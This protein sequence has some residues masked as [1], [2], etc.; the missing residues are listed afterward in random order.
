M[1]THRARPT[2]MRR[3]Q[4]SKLEPSYTPPVCHCYGLQVSVRLLDPAMK[5][6]R[7]QLSAALTPFRR[8]ICGLGLT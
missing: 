4:R 5:W 7:L 1:P 3:V 2:L 8:G 6:S